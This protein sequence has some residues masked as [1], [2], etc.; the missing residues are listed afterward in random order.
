MKTTLFL[1]GVCAVAIAIAA[2]AR[3]RG[4]EPGPPQSRLVAALD[5][6][7]DGTISASEMRDAAAAL[8]TLDANSD[9][10]L[11]ADELRPA[12]GRRGEFGGPRGRG[13]DRERGGPPAASADDLA[14]TLMSFDKDGDGKLARSEVPDRFQG[15][16][17]RADGNKDGALTR[18][19]LKQS[20]DAARPGDGGRGRFGG[21]GGGSA[22]DPLFRAIDRDRD[23]ALTEAEIAGAPEALKTLDANGDGQLSGDEIRPPFMRGFRG[24][25]GD[26]R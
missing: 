26:R 2:A 19:E 20:A 12:F 1:T 13:E 14:D 8:K 16:F 21:R 25:E 9:G 22:M 4:F 18:D 3:N 11:T 10:R 23:G 5:A 7:H 15:L 24:R 17:D 6:D